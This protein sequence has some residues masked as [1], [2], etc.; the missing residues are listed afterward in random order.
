MSFTQQ[1][2]PRPQIKDPLIQRMQSPRGCFHDTETNFAVS[3]LWLWISWHDATRKCHTGPSRHVVV[4]VIIYIY[5]YLF[6]VKKKR[7]KKKKMTQMRPNQ[8]RAI[9]TF[10]ITPTTWQFAAYPN[11]TQ[12]QKAVKISNKNSSFNWVHS[13]HKELTNASLSTNLFTNSCH[14]ISTNGKAPLH[15]HINQQHP[16]IPLFALMKG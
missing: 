6:D 13:I 16:T 11:T 3:L 8:L 9:L 4:G 2:L 10:L 14:H 1:L 7:K 5:I 12:T 15:S